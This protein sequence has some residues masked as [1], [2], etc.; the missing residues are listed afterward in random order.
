MQ[1]IISSLMFHKK[2]TIKHPNSNNYLR[3]SFLLYQNYKL[4]KFSQDTEFPLIFA[5]VVKKIE[6]KKEKKSFL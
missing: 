6:N 3:I 4:G 5:K 2:N 1:S